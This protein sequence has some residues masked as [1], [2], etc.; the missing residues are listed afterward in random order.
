MIYEYSRDF[1]FSNNRYT[2]TIYYTKVDKITH[3][4]QGHIKR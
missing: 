1:C 3:K 4:V 2:G